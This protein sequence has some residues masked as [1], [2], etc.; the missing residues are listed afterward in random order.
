MMRQLFVIDPYLMGVACVSKDEI[1]ATCAGLKE[2]GLYRLPYPEI[3]LRIPATYVLGDDGEIYW[4][5]TIP[6]K[7]AVAK[8]EFTR[9]DYHNYGVTIR[10]LSEDPKKDAQ[11]F[12]RC[13]CE[14]CHKS[15]KH[16]S[17]HT[18]KLISTGCSV[19]GVR[20]DNFDRM[21]CKDFRP[22]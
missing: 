5:V 6:G 10:G 22:N 20:G 18:V 1:A 14:E 2:M 4:D 7:Q 8:D 12:V 11:L 16:G 13:M 9:P 19:D 17:D 15:N 3:D 21:V